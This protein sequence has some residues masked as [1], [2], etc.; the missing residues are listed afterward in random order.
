MMGSRCERHA[1]GA[2]ASAWLA[3]AFVAVIAAATSP[4]NAS[5]SCLDQADAAASQ[6]LRQDSTGCWTLDSRLRSEAPSAIR[7]L[8]LVPEGADFPDPS[9]DIP[10]DDDEVATRF[11]LLV[12]VVLAT[13]SG[14]AAFRPESSIR[15]TSPGKS[16]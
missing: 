12:S 2:V 8:I 5:R 11:L 7:E 9:P 1:G 3:A 14:F 6:R 4:A 13:A 16:W 15:R 10:L